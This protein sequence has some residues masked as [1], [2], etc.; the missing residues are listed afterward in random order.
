MVHSVDLESIR[1]QVINV[2]RR[3]NTDSTRSLTGHALEIS[4][5]ITFVVGL[6]VPVWQ[7]IKIDYYAHISVQANLLADVYWIAVG[8]AIEL[9]GVCL[10]LLADKRQR[11]FWQKPAEK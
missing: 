1:F 3:T 5:V 4:G 6:L 11:V 10:I 8:M 7:T 9:F 2:M